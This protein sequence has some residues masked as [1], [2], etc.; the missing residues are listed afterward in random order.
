[1]TKGGS[2][3]ITIA[4][5]VSAAL[6]LFGIPTATRAA[7]SPLSL[8]PMVIARQGAFEIGGK[9]I[10]TA[11]KTLSCDHG[12]MEYQIPQRPRAVSMVMWHSSSAKVWQTRWDGGE[13]FQSMFLRR[14][15]PVYLWDGPRV[16]RANWSCE[17]VTSSAAPGA[18]QGNFAAWRLGT[19]WPNWFPGVQFPIASPEAWDQATRARYEEFD[20]TSNVRLQSDAAALA[21]DK[22]GPVVILTNSAGGF[23][24][25]MTHIK[26]ETSNIK[27]IVA[28]ENPGFVF[29]SGE[30]PEQTPGM[31][32]PLEV[33][34]ADFKK[35]TKIPMQFVWGDNIDKT[36]TPFWSKTFR[37]CRA[38][39]EAVNRHGGRAE[40]LRLRDVGLAGN[41]HI[42]FADLNNDKVAKQL[43]IFLKRNRLNGY[44]AVPKRAKNPA[45][46]SL[47]GS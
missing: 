31:F 27:A 21:M 12:Y 41:T 20:T 34:L 43:D 29:P 26:A 19:S 30:M 25:I 28:Y 9:I 8:P 3:R 22:I 5:T 14:G 6:L 37:L 1:M 2:C 10:G 42:P 7:A 39:V 36:S 4:H 47:K 44:A 17:A 40:I 18:D 33:S 23:R 38:F 11:A 15:Y 13:G 35:L 24:A 45:V 46:D 32:G 16:G